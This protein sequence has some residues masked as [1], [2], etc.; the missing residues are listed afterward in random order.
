MELYDPNIAPDPAAW[1]ALAEG[2]RLELVQNAHDEELDDLPS[3]TLHCA[4]HVAVETQVAMGEQLP[5]AGHLARLV[6]EGL[7]RHEAVH[8]VA[9]VLAE[10][11]F[12]IMKQPQE[13]SRDPNEAYHAAL[14]RL[15]A[16]KWRDS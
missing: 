11:M 16:R 14:L 9:S 8:A 3:P 7:A 2:E 6:S 13:F 12:K 15:S 1:L 10:H 4:M 5:V